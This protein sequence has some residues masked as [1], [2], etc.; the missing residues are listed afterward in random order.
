GELTDLAI[1]VEVGQRPAVAGLPFPD[2]RRCVPTRTA[3]VTVNAVDAG[4]QLSAEKPLR[5]W[6]LPFE[7]LGPGRGPLEFLREVLPESFGIRVGARI[8]RVVANVGFGAK[9][10]SRLECAI[11]LEE[12]CD[13][14]EW[15]AVCHVRGAEEG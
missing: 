1:Q 6:R 3:D 4:I 14:S 2:D 8:H 13:F 7:H 12:I 15:L 11:F 5:V 9:R 10:R